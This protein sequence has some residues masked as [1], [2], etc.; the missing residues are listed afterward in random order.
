LPVGTA[1][2][3]RLEERSLVFGVFLANAQI[4]GV[5]T[6]AGAC[7]TGREAVFVPVLL[8]DPPVGR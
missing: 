8:R 1:G 2:G 4:A 6:R 3:S 5:Y 7:I